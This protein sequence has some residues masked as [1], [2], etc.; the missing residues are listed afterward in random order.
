MT[1]KTISWK[2]V[3]L[4]ISIL[5]I[6]AMGLYL[7]DGLNQTASGAGQVFYE[8]CARE[9]AQ[10]SNPD[11]NICNTE[12]NN[13]KKLIWAE[14][15]YDVVKILFLPILFFWIFGYSVAAI[16]RRLK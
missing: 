6:L 12:Q 5:W 9:Q 8:S 7:Y 14:Q 1:K 4:T 13:V 10:L 2:T 16:K 15:K 11:L 3:S